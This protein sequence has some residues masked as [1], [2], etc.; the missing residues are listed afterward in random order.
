[1]TTTAWHMYFKTSQVTVS[2]N[3]RSSHPTCT[4]AKP[5]F[6]SLNI[7][8]SRMR[9]TCSQVPS[10]RHGVWALWGCTWDGLEW[11]HDLGFEPLQQLPHSRF[12]R[13]QAACADNPARCCAVMKAYREVMDTM[14]ATW[15]IC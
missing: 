14:T 9:S 6:D 10:A 7:S 11:I 1:M 2:T 4:S 5:P 8:F 13:T 3:H 15:Q 12:D